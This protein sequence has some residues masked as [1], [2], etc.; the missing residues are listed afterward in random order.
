MEKVTAL[1]AAISAG[2]YRVPAIDIADKLIWFMRH[3]VR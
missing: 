1:R 2:K 3:E